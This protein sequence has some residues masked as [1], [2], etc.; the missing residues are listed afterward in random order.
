MFKTTNV[1]VGTFLP[2]TDSFSRFYIIFTIVLKR[3]MY[4]DRLEVLFIF[5][6]GAVDKSTKHYLAMFLRRAISA[7]PEIVTQ[8]VNDSE[9]K[10][11]MPV[12]E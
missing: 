8:G 2:F 12:P 3:F 6:V 4:P 10:K 11:K 5:H 7:R 1:S 9:S